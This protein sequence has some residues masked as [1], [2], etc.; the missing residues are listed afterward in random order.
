MKTLH[1]CYMHPY[2][3]RWRKPFRKRFKMKT[4]FK[5]FSLRFVV[6]LSLCAWQ[7]HRAGKETCIVGHALTVHRLYT[8]FVN[9]HRLRCTAL[10]EE[11]LQK[12]CSCSCKREKHFR[13]ELEMFPNRL[14]VNA[15]W[16][17]KVHARGEVLCMMGHSPLE[18]TCIPGEVLHVYSPSLNFKVIWHLWHS[19]M[20]T[21]RYHRRQGSLL[22]SCRTTERMPGI[23]T[24]AGLDACTDQF[25][26][27]TLTSRG[28]TLT[29]HALH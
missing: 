28:C 3:R 5:V 9:H 19:Y 17:G 26:L 13:N 20:H 12:R 22:V 29:N 25:I 10:V 4:H 24:S 1:W 11:T 15:A 23:N 2:T 18:G 21:H 6:V 16:V 8:N 14:L 7:K 27:H